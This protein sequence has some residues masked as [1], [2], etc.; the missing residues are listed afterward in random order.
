MTISRQTFDISTTATRTDTGPPFNGAIKQVRWQ[1][2]SADTGG[3]MT[4]FLQQRLED[5]GDGIMIFTTGDVASPLLADFVLLP[6]RLVTDTGTTNNGSLSESVV[7]AGEHLRV[8]TRPGTN[9]SGK[10][11]VWTCDD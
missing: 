9:L 11:Y 2:S 7:S 5:T 10:L 6:R 3:N 1:T 8:R 4:A